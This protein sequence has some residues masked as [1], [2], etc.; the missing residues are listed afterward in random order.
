MS[1]FNGMTKNLEYCQE[2]QVKLCKKLG[3]N[4]IFAHLGYQNIN[5]IWEEGI[6]GD[7]LVERYKKILK[8]ARKTE[9]QW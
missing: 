2:E 8:T 4:I 6:D 3:F 5:S 9:Y 7:N 1:L